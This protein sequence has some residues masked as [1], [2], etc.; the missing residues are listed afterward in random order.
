MISIQKT[1]SD[2][3]DFK[4]L[5]RLFD[6]YLVDID[7]DEKDF[8]AQFNQIYLDY[9]I[10]Y[11]ENEIAIGCGAFKEY[12]PK[13]AEI[14]RMFVLPEQRG[15]G[16]AVSILKELEIW[17]KAS[18]YQYTMLETSVRLESAIALYK[19]SGYKVIPNYGQYIGVASSVCMKKSIK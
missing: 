8:F 4:H 11:Y 12:E 5:T 7:G 3:P 17:A 10:V 6:E 2:N 9:V 18:G 1:T 15:K 19:K 16:I 13:V 14:K